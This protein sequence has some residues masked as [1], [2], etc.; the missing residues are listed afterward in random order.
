[1]YVLWTYFE[2]I[3]GLLAKGCANPDMCMF[4]REV[5]SLL[6]WCGIDLEK[7]V[8][9]ILVSVNEM[10]HDFPVLFVIVIIIIMD[11]LHGHVLYFLCPYGK[12]LNKGKRQCMLC[13]HMATKNT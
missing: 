7:I 6:V 2:F 3:F 11:I 4:I 10:G 12:M 9:F 8:S 5:I 13:V 1:M